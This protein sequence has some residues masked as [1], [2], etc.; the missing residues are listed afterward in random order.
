MGADLIV[1]G[2]IRPQGCEPDWPG[3]EKHVHGLSDDQLEQLA[4]ILCWDDD[5]PESTRAALLGLVA[6]FRKLFEE[7]PRD[8]DTMTFAGLHY[9]MTGGLSYGDE[10]TSSFGTI[11]DFVNAGLAGPAGFVVAAPPL[12]SIDRLVRY[13]GEQASYDPDHENVFTHVK[14]VGEWLGVMRGV[15]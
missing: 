2:V 9:T 6:D 11:N 5:T 3:A 4:D 1:V 13:A 15:R 14:A 12:D 7:P 10:P 8:V